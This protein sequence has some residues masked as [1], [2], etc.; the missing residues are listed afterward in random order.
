M[1]TRIRLPLAACALLALGMIGCG[2]G[3]DGPIPID[4]ATCVGSASCTPNLSTECT[5]ADGFGGDGTLAG[6]GCLD[7]DECADRTDDCVEAGGI[8]TNTSGSFECSCDDGFVGDGTNGGTGCTDVDECATSTDDCVGTAVCTNNP[9]GYTC[10]CPTGFEGDGT[11]AGTGCTDLDECA[12]NTD[13]CV[14]DND[15]GW[16]RNTPGSFTCA[17]DEDN[18]G[19]G[20]PVADGGTG[21]VERATNPRLVIPRRM[22]NDKTL[23]LRADILDNAGKINTS[24]CFGT[25]GNVRMT[26]I[27]DGADVPISITIFDD[28]IAN[29]ADSIR[30][31]HGVGSISITLDDGA[32]VPA[33]DY[34]VSV[35]VGPLRASRVVHVLEDPTWRVMPDQLQGADLVWGPHE[36]IRLSAHATEVP[37]GKTLT[38]NPGT[39]IMVDTTGG[40]ENGTLLNVNGTIDAPGT[41]ARP[42]HIFSERGAAAMTHAITSSLS[43]VNSWR[44]I[45]FFGNGTSTLKFLVL[46]GAGNGV[47]VSHPRPPIINMFGSHNLTAE[48]LVLVDSTGMGFQTPGN[49]T[50]TIRRSLISR[51]GIGGE[52]LSSGHTLQ[53]EDTWWAGIG[54]GPSTPIRYDGDAI[55]VDGAGSSQ[56]IKGNVIVDV[57]DDCIDHS[58]STF[59]IENTMIHDCN[60]KAV[61]LTNGSITVR[62]SLLYDAGTGIRGTARVVNSTIAVTNAPVATVESATESI[63]WSGSVPTCTGAVSYSIVG[64]PADLGCGMGNQSVSPRYTNEGQCNYTPSAGSPALTAGPMG[65][66][67]GWQGFPSW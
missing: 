43:N 58:N 22:V 20:I 19:N 11:A 6:T 56:L 36:N 60:D 25:L 39:I 28:H 65:G 4:C 40:L 12:A 8:C 47:V 14:G 7:L 13:N 30:F 2:G 34:R 15:G 31:Y 54:R 33:G 57:G 27:S 1:R 67:I 26:R 29:P 37:A 46:T 66:R 64:N 17:C 62:N 9:G 48:D 49:G 5:C 59:T 52:F 18:D 24:G 41:R 61:S 3:Y 51:V 55:H 32:A 44:G 45:F 21:C 35:G 10:A 42:I 53:I 38:I 63:I 16:C 50:Y 23:T